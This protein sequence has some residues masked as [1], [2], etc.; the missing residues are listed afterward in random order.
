SCLILLQ[1]RNPFAFPASDLTLDFCTFAD[2]SSY[3]LSLI[4]HLA[5][6]LVNALPSTHPQSRHC[7]IVGIAV[8]KK[9]VATLINTTS[10]LDLNTS[11]FSHH[12]G[13][14]PVSK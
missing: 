8:Y 4:C 6:L 14:D 3:L 9:Q 10:A 5:P 2:A 12:N 7:S 13:S 11:S 1:V